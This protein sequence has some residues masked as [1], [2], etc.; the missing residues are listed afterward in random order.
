M[1]VLPA[2]V[3]QHRLDRRRRPRPC[4]GART[5]GPTRSPRPAMPGEQ[6]AGLVRLGASQARSPRSSAS[7]RSAHSRSCPNGLGMR[8][9]SANSSR[10]PGLLGLGR[11]ASRAVCRP[12]CARDLLRA[13]ARARGRARRATN[14]RN[15]GAGRSGRDLN[16]GWYCEATKNGWSWISMISTSRS[17]G[18]VPEI[19]RPGGLEPLAQEVVDLVA[20]A[21]A[22]V[23]D[24]LAVELARLACRRAA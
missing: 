2:A 20:V 18:D 8:H 6:V 17:S 16:S 12:A 21:V 10:E 4:R 3:D 24:G 13:A 22:L 1:G 5:A 15:S 14:S 23:D 9:S 7:T 11:A 19:T